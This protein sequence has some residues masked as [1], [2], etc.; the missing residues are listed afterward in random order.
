METNSQ[1]SSSLVAV[2]RDR[3]NLLEREESYMYEIAVSKRAVIEKSA[4]VNGLVFREPL[5]CCV[6]SRWV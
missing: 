5:L 4:L 6:F 1:P 3:V 2:R